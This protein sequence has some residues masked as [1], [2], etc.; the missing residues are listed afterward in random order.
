MRRGAEWVV[1][2]RSVRR[3]FVMG[4]RLR[5]KLNYPE[6]RAALWESLRVRPRKNTIGYLRFGHKEF[7]TRYY[8]PRITCHII[9]SACRKGYLLRGMN[10]KV[11]LIATTPPNLRRT[12]CRLLEVVR[13]SRNI[14]IPFTLSRI[15]FH[16]VVMF[17]TVFLDGFRSFWRSSPLS[18]SDFCNSSVPPG[19]IP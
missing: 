18:A 10:L 2:D 1:V 9:S 5:E 7:D 11:V 14:T 17:I 3:Y 4:R 16:G 8:N 19:P 13:L 15:K 12:H 6:G